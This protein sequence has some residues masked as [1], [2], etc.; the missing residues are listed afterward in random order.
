MK[1]IKVGEF[2]IFGVRTTVWASEEH[3]TGETNRL[4]DEAHMT[5]GCIAPAPWMVESILLHELMERAL[6]DYGCTFDQHDPYRKFLSSATGRLFVFNH[7]LLDRITVMVAEAMK[8]VRGPL[9]KVA[10]KMNGD[11][12]IKW[13]RV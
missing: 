12:G 7:D 8:N 6:L 13:G 5:I 9:M 11:L 10:K 3:M 1:K 2:D 4:D